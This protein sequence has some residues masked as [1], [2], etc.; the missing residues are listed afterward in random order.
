MFQN[1]AYGRSSDV[2]AH[3]AWQ[4]FIPE[5]LHKD[6]KSAVKQYNE[7]L[8]TLKK[9]KELSSKQVDQ[10]ADPKIFIRKWLVQVK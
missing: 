2:C 10:F 7:I 9:G 3:C 4:D 6:H 8:D 1:C 5:V